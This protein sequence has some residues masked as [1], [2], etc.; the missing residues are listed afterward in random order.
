MQQLV[1]ADLGW[2]HLRPIQI[3]AAAPVLAADRDVL[4]I[5][6][7]ASGKTEA[8]W[9]PVFSRLLHDDHGGIGAICISPLKALIN[10]QAVRL[11]RYGQRL[12]LGVKPWHGDISQAR[13]SEALRHPPAALLITPE[14]LQSLLLRRP[15][16]F[17]R[18][19]RNLRYLMV[20]E[21]HAF[22]GTDRGHQ[23][24]A[25]L[26]H[27]DLRLARRIPRIA[28]SATVSDAATMASFLRPGGGEKVLVLRAD[29]PEGF[30]LD[31]VV[32]GYDHQDADVDSY[33]M[34]DEQQKALRAK[35]VA[36]RERLEIARRVDAETRGRRSLVFARSRREV[37]Q[38]AALLR[39]PEVTGTH[40]ADRFFTHHGSLSPAL[41][42][43]AEHAIHT[44]ADATV[45]CTST[46]ELGVDLPDLDRVIQVD[47]CVSAGSL[48]Q[49][50]GRSG[51]R[52]GA[53][54][55]LR[56]HVTE[57]PTDDGPAIADLL[58]AGLVETLAIIALINEQDWVE[59]PD[60]APLGLST[61]VQQV[62]ALLSDANGCSARQAWRLLC[63]A[64]PWRSISPTDFEA[65]LRAM[66]A[67][68]LI[69]QDRLGLLLLDEAGHAIVND[70][71]FVVAFAAQPE[72]TL[73]HRGRPLG[74]IGIEHPLRGNDLIA[75][76]GMPWRVV[77]VHESGWSADVEPAGHGQPV[78]WSG[79]GGP[80][81]HKAVRRR[82]R[83]IYADDTVPPYLDA[84]RPRSGS[85]PRGLGVRCTC[86]CREANS[87]RPARRRRAV[88]RHARHPSR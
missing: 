35:D 3:Q 88:A 74:S 25:L 84:R 63:A 40:R 55:T 49:R 45:V 69:R 86:R 41:R 56:V 7:T 79:K 30:D 5:S 12:N 87:A 46:L 1:R 17:M 15:E 42:H 54:P 19:A 60:L 75:F 72:L 18:A 6:G 50:L 43:A 65:L 80:P 22:A 29:N 51:R 83:A 21:I 81:V 36:P 62:L 9:L 82:M 4:I 52:D 77:A 23:L 57:K 34:T 76:G 32:Y 47:A 48:R 8:A 71:D 10:D 85:Q 70:R 11:S 2:R 20:D 66:A 26:S 38:L 53:R 59:P 58:R 16:T 27:M 37:E 24:Q 73:L 39:D 44:V 68:Q 13:K 28:L 67:K 33:N 78:T 64:G 31:V 14:S 61:L